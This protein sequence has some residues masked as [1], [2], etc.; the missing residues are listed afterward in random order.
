MDLPTCVLTFCLGWRDIFLL[1]TLPGASPPEEKLILLAFSEFPS[2]TLVMFTVSHQ[3]ILEDIVAVD[4]Q[5]LRL[6][7]HSIFRLKEVVLQCY[8][9]THERDLVST[10][11][12]H[13]YTSPTKSAQTAFL[14]RTPLKKFS[15]KAEGCR[16]FSARGAS[17]SLFRL[18]SLLT[19]SKMCSDPCS[20]VYLVAEVIEK[21]AVCSI[22]SA[23]VYLAA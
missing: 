14:G 23:R 17:C 7:P 13:V 12:Q 10:L 2:S 18:G 21:G 6:S 8:W 20:S 5:E 11:F 3:E 22:S 4:R 1:P 16:M 9:Q 15:G 19:T